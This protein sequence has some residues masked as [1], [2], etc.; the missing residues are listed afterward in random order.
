MDMLRAD[1]YIS[2]NSLEAKVPFGDLD[3]VRY[4]MSIDPELKLNKYGKGKISLTPRL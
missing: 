1:R 4:I 2:V 3:F